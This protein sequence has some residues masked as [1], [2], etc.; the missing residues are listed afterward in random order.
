[1]RGA[2]RARRAVTVRSRAAR[3]DAPPSLQVKRR[4]VC[5]SISDG[6]K[7]AVRDALAGKNIEQFERLSLSEE[8]KK[9]F[10][11]LTTSYEIF[12]GKCVT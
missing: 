11:R 2:G 3:R 8:Q 10:E 9:T 1:M 7:A 5:T 12:L 6:R 4:T